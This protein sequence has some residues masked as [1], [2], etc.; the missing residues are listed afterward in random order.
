VFINNESNLTDL[1]RKNYLYRLNWIL[2]LYN[3]DDSKIP[4]YKYYIFVED[5][6]NNPYTSNIEDRLTL[7]EDIAINQTIIAFTIDERGLNEKGLDEKI[8][9]GIKY[10]W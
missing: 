2:K 4:S 9:K 5:A 1:K 6:I 10:Y 3:K 8:V 7:Y